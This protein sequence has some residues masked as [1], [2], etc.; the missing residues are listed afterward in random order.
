MF[1]YSLGL[2]LAKKNSTGLVVDTTF[3]ND[4]FPRGVI[5]RNYD[6]DIFD[7]NPEFA[8]L[9]K[10]SRKVPV[11]GLWLGLD[12][13]LVVAGDLVG[14]RKMVR[15]RDISRFDPKV[16]EAPKAS[17]LWGFWQSP[18]YFEDI[19]SEVRETFRFRHELSDGAREMGDR[20]R[21]SNS[22][23]LSVRRSDYTKASNTKLFGET[24]TDYY[25]RAIE[26]IASRIPSPHFFIFSD[27][28]AWCRK[29]IHPPFKTTYV[30]EE[31][32]G[33]KWKFALELS[34]LCKHQIIANS[35]FYWWGAWLNRNPDKVVVAPKRWFQGM[36]GDRGDIIPAGWV[37]L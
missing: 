13:G 30:P 9:G 2:N 29:N 27:D 18:K 15:E 31:I 1:Q 17:V 26:H 6:L 19:E 5:F 4:R 3:L 34:S 35:T 28:V 14:V 33:P 8:P 32:R 16:L 22:V 24:D 36:D 11:P 20:M 25:D 37:R 12:L 10:I 23:A 7:V 21:E